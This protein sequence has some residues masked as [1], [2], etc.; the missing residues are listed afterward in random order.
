[1]FSAPNGE[2]RSKRKRKKNGKIGLV[3]ECFTEM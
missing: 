1:M 3:D 2:E